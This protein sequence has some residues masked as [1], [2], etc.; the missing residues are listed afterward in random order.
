MVRQAHLNWRFDEHRPDNVFK[1]RGVS[2]QALPDFPFRDDTLL[3]WK[4][5]RNFVEGYLGLYYADDGDVVEDEEL[6]NWIAELT[7][8]EGA[9]VKGM[10][11][12]VVGDGGLRI[13]TFDYLCDLSLI[14]I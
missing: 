7:S 8:E 14:H 10:S 4:A 5:I 6:Q 3:L 12:L 2:T 11:G 1:R 9:A 13:R